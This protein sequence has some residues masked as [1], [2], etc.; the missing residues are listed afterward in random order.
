[1]LLRCREVLLI[2]T[3]TE[4]NRVAERNVYIATAT[5]TM[6]YLSADTLSR[7]YTRLYIIDQL[8]PC[9]N[10]EQLFDYPHSMALRS[11]LS[12]VYYQYNI[13]Y[14]VNSVTN[15]YFATINC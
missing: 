2:G 4:R 11:F 10:N 15:I 1:M 9:R 3:I 7:A 13:G 14:S 6:L 12:T 5:T 8:R